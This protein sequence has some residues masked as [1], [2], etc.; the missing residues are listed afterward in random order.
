MVERHHPPMAD[1]PRSP[2]R[3][4]A[5]EVDGDCYVDPTTRYARKLRAYARELHASCDPVKLANN[6]CFDLGESVYVKSDIPFK[7]SKRYPNPNQSVYS[8]PVLV[9]AKDGNKTITVSRTAHRGYQ[10]V[11]FS[12]IQPCFNG[13]IPGYPADPPSKFETTTRL[14]RGE[15]ACC[16]SIVKDGDKKTYYV[17]WQGFHP[18]WVS[19]FREE[20]FN[21][22]DLKDILVRWRR[23]LFSTGSSNL[24]W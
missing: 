9:T 21:R 15:A 7:I 13:V 10:T 6:T 4:K 1:P 11:P 12:D 19:W 23:F 18:F 20:E 5:E 16:V 24:T 8:G 17:N 3:M 22:Q 14:Q 2:P